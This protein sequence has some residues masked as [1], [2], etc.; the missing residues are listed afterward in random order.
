[1]TGSVSIVNMKVYASVGT[2]S[3]LVGS[4]YYY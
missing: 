2:V 3:T 4:A 1:V